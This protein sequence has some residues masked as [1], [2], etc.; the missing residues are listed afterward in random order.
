MKF[1]IIN[2]FKYTF[3]FFYNLINNKNYIII[4]PGLLGKLLKKIIIFD[5]TYKNFFSIKIRNKF[6]IITIFE[7]FAQDF[8]NVKNLNISDEINLI[9]SKF[10]KNKLT[11]LIIDCGANI[12]CSGIYFEKMIENC[13]VI[14]IEPEEKNFS[15]LQ[16]NCNSKIYKNINSAVSSKIMKFSIENLSNDDRAFRI[17]EN[18]EGNKNTVTI[19]EILLNKDKKLKP[20]LIKF[21]IE[22]FEKDVFRENLDWMDEFKIIIIEIHDWMLPGE[23][24][25][26][27]FFK[28]ISNM[29]KDLI[30]SGENLILINN[31]YKY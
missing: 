29:K 20:F 25:S 30:I 8:Y 21:D 24:C 6:D 17:K 27:N 18:Q 15:L 26:E 2:L 23:N 7:I 4:T 12:G 14:N 28:A 10:K 16:L 11:P 19:N 1:F 3:Y 22:G 9:I 13:H 5:N 31:N